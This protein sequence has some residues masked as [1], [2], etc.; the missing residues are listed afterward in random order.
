MHFGYGREFLESY[1]DRLSKVTAAEVQRFAREK[2]HP[3][4]MAIVLVGNSAKFAEVLKQKY[5]AFETI[6]VTE[7]DFLRSDLRKPKAAPAP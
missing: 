2:M 7:I 6:P 1:D 3:D 5:G 4:R